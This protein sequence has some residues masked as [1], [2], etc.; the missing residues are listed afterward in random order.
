MSGCN[1]TGCSAYSQA[2]APITLGD[3]P[4]TP[5]ATLD[6]STITVDWTYIPAGTAKVEVFVSYE[7]RDWVDVTN[8]ASRVGSSNYQAVFAGLDSGTRVFKTRSCDSQSVCSAFSELSNETVIEGE[9][10]AE[11]GSQIIFVHTDLL[12]SPTVETTEK[13]DVL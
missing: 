11:E 2:S 13:G 3:R 4:S 6:G 8:S 7:S 5:V 1:N 12:G 9:T 10:P